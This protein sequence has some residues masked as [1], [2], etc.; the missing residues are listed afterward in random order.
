MLKR[1]A[2]TPNDH[3]MK[4]I[5]LFLGLSLL[6]LN[7]WS[8][9]RN[10]TIREDPDIAHVLVR[11]QSTYA[12]ILGYRGGRNHFMEVGIG[13]MGIGH[14]VVGWE[15]TYLSNLSRNTPIHG[16]AIGYFRGFAFFETGL[17]ATALSGPNSRH[18]LFKPSLGLGIGGIATVN[19]G[20]NLSL[21]KLGTEV[22]PNR[23]EVR[24][25]IRWP[26]ER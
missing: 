1:G 22:Q 17:Q 26:L 20:Y 18:I 19:Y 23:H 16:A 14:G 11:N 2:K 12:P 6:L 7:G 25:V 5:L 13:V 24:V 4:P 9:G 3:L 8:Q 10:D 21:F 15:I